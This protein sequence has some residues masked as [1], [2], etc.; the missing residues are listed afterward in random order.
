M[1]L[2]SCQKWLEAFGRVQTNSIIRNSDGNF[3]HCQF[4]WLTNIIKINCVSISLVKSKLNKSSVDMWA[5]WG[6][7]VLLWEKQNGSEFPYF[8]YYVL[9]PAL[10][11]K[12]IDL[13]QVCTPLEQQGIFICGVWLVNSTIREH[14][15]SK[16]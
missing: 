13:L 1:H 8:F 5:V 16:C 11:L 6:C 10:Q 9:F 15:L 14:R 3:L 2:L 7:C 4:H 12:E